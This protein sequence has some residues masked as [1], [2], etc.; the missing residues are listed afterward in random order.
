MA[1]LFDLDGTLLDH[2]HAAAAAIA[3]WAA[4][5]DAPAPPAGRT[6]ASWWRELEDL[7]FERFERAETT[8][9]GQRVGRTR[10]FLNRPDLSADE[11]LRYYDGYLSAYRDNWLAYPDAADALRRALA[12]G[13]SVGVLTN[14]AR[15]M[16]AAKLATTGLDLPGVTLLPTVEWGLTKPDP[17]AYQRG[18]AELGV[19]R[20]PEAATPAVMI[21]DNFANDVA[22]A[23]AAGLAAVL[24]TRGH[25]P[26][27]DGEPAITSLDQ[28]QFSPG[29]ARI[30]DA[31]AQA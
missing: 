2:E 18:L 31:P 13:D 20:E 27:P 15:E 7:W 9:Q 21:G 14:G 17:R 28:L 25:A 16:Q 5:M 4:A 23:R 12:T 11:A 24:V 3:T 22:A 26:V 6:L 29:A 1:I 19:T 8:H 10:D 30:T